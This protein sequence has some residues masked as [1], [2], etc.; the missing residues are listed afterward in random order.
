MAAWLSL[1]QTNCYSYEQVDRNKIET[2]NRVTAM[3]LEVIGG[4]VVHTFNSR[5]LRG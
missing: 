3:T 5:T 1:T 2:R 4:I